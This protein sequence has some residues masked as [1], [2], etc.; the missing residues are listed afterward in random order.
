MGSAIQKLQLLLRGL[1]MYGQTSI[2][3]NITAVFCTW[4]K[5]RSFANDRLTFD[6]HGHS[7]ILSFIPGAALS[8]LQCGRLHVSR[9]YSPKQPGFILLLL[10]A[11]IWSVNTS[12]PIPPAAIHGHAETWCDALDHKLFLVFSPDLSV[13][14]ILIQFFLSFNS[15]NQIQELGSMS[16]CTLAISLLAFLVHEC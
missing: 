1:K 4:V 7:H 14:M 13:P 11:V 9:E 16:R 5:I 10:S 12:D 15:S 8:G 2:I 6:Y 3:V